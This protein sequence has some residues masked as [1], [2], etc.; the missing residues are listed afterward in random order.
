MGAFSTLKQERWCELKA[1]A[2]YNMACEFEYLNEHREAL[3]YQKK[4]MD[5]Y[6]PCESKNPSFSIHLSKGQKN[7]RNLILKHFKQKPVSR[8]PVIMQKLGE[9]FTRNT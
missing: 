6:E 4:A 7:C 9:G 3:N 8:D 1:I 2:F 5:V